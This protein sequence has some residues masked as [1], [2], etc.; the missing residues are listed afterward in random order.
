MLSR[1]VRLTVLIAPVVFA[2]TAC[3]SFSSTGPEEERV[4]TRDVAALF[5]TSSL[6]YTARMTPS[7]IDFTVPFTFTNRTGGP[8]YFVNC[9]GVTGLALEKWVHSQWED[10]WGPIINGCLS[11]PIVVRPDLQQE[12]IVFVTASYLGSNA[13]PQFGTDEVEGV[14]RF[15]WREVLRDY[16]TSRRPLGEL[17]PLDRRISNR[18]ELVA[19]IAPA[20]AQRMAQANGLKR[21][22]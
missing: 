4:L 3:D 1:L 5:Q 2:S 22:R 21:G 13:Y 17:L 20:P 15:V 14:Y 11:P 10:V 7:G 8:A 12:G 19:Q 9:D 16:D 6:R 18:F